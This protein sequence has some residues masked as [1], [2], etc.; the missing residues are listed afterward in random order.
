MDDFFT[1]HY[2]TGAIINQLTAERAQVVP[3]LRW[4]KFEEA[5]TG[6]FQEKSTRVMS[7]IGS[8]VKVS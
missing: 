1:L 8:T 5:L 2:K 4:N 7:L 6:E 3:A